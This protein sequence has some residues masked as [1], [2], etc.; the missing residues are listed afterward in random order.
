MCLACTAVISA[1][2]G[3]AEWTNTAGLA[4]NSYY[5]SNICRVPNDEEEKLVG[6]VT[7]NVNLRGE[8]A[9]AFVALDAAV[10]YNT[11]GESSLE[12]PQGGAGFGV[13]NRE[14]WV[15]RINFLSEFE[16][17]E[18][19]L[20]LEADAF[21]AQN[22]V[23]PFV[24]GGDDNINGVG[25][26]NITSRWGAG[27]RIQRQYSERWAVL[28]RYNYN[29]QYNS[30]NQVLGDSQEDRVELDVGM[31]PEASRFS[32]GVRGQYSEVTFDETLT[33]PEFVNRLSRLELRSALQLSRSWQ[34]NAYGGEEDNV[35]LSSSDEVDGSYWDVGLRWA[36][37]DRVTV[38]AG[39]GERFFGDA[40]RF[41]ISYRHK[42]TQ[43][44]ASYIRD[45]QFPRNIRAADGGEVASD[46]L[47]PDVGLPGDPLAGAGGP[48]FIGQT[49]V[50][51]EN[52]T[53]SYR[54]NARRTTFSVQ[55]NDSQ[56]TRAENGSTGSFQNVT[57]IV[58]RQLGVSLSGDVRLGWRNNEG[59]I[60]GTG[61]GL[62]GQN[63]EAWTVGLGVQQKLGPETILSLRYLY[64]DQTSDTD[65]NTFEEN[66]VDLGLRFSF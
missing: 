58:T 61:G 17:V 26:T 60:N 27:A 23:N 30:F 13:A 46:P 9:R 4:V 15:P 21:A 49:P 63:L 2:G 56:Q 53:L 37:N 64:T 16:A 25:N 31:I 36:P 35:F 5:S 59:D 62:F 34:L 44:T 40:P 51:N 3:A 11:L 57:A 32:L 50:L 47:N 7:P 42:R 41:D 20:F 1:G 66:R 6:T 54:F 33:Q 24:T 8:G 28:A 22:S 65:F 12:C 43:L 52:F 39:Y 14:T 10:E 45:L 18:N 55:A 29:E 48:T 19:F 38:N